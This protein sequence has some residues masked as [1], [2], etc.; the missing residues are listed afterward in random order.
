MRSILLFLL[1]GAD[2]YNVHINS[3]P[4]NENGLPQFPPFFGP[5]PAFG[6]PPQFGPPPALGPPPQ[7]GPPPPLG[8]PPQFLPPSPLRQPPQFPPPPPLRQSP[9]FTPSPSLELTSQLAPHLPSGSLYSSEPIGIP[10][11]GGQSTPLG[12]PISDN[13]RSTTSPSAESQQLSK[14]KY[15]TSNKGK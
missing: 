6:P 10:P 2:I 3:I 4:L 9:Q 12:S 7:F 5:P 1:I 15:K 13:D 14:E 11:S 8:Q